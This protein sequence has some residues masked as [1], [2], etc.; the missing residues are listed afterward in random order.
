MGEKIIPKTNQQL[1]TENKELRSRWAEAE[2]A[3]YAIINGEVDAIVVSG[4]D[5]EQIYSIS[6][7]ETPYRTFIE[8]MNEGAVTLSKDG[9]II[10]CNRRFAEFVNEPIEQVFGSHLIRFI[11]SCDKSE[12]NSLLTLLSSKKNGVQVVSL[13]NSMYLKLTFRHLPS[14]LN[15]ESC[16]IIATDITEI[17]KKEIELCEAQRLL[18]QNLDQIKDLRIDLINAKINSGVAIKN[19]MKSN[20]KL[21]KLVSKQK[22]LEAEMKQG[23]KTNR[24]GL[25]PQMKH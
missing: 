20:E 16:I 11:A 15:G 8:E 2:E 22:L 18:K 3:L 14:Y 13:I 4:K 7:A 21:I 9:V 19:L 12:F 25:P 24:K 1:V 5:R 23:L 10:Y 17:K 6:S